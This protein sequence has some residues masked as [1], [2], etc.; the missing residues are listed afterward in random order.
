VSHYYF[1]G[2][3]EPLLLWGFGQDIPVFG[4]CCGILVLGAC[5]GIVVFGA[6]RGSSFLYW[7]WRFLFAGY[8]LVLRL[9]LCLSCPSLLFPVFFWIGLLL[10]RSSFGYCSIS[11]FS[12]FVLG[13]FGYAGF[14]DTR[15]FSCISSCFPCGLHLLYWHAGFFCISSCF[16]FLIQR[17][18]AGPTRGKYHHILPFKLLRSRLTVTLTL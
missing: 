7:R 6:C 18:L 12:S 5:Y 9:S 17:V 11:R 14:L 10:D 1:G 3:G 2:S 16:S 15:F 8:L 4:A 13:R